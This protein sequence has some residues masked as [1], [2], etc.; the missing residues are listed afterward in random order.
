MALRSGPHLAHVPATLSWFQVRIVDQLRAM[1]QDDVHIFVTRCVREAL[2][3]GGKFFS[4]AAAIAAKFPLLAC[5]HDGVA[6]GGATVV[7]AHPE[8]DCLLALLGTHNA[9]HLLIAAQQSSLR[10]KARK[11]PG[12][13]IVFLQ[14][15]VP[16][17]DDISPASLKHSQLVRDWHDVFCIIGSV[18]SC[19]LVLAPRGKRVAVCRPKRN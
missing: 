16:L 15:Q 1:L 9:D 14:G 5:R 18:P 11:V 4:G 6:E 3:A 13:P 19:R 8:R 17:L 10:E 2:A 12:C 7:S